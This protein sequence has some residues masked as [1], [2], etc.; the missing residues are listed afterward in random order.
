MRLNL[1]LVECGYAIG[2]QWRRSVKK[3]KNKMSSRI[4]NSKPA[5]LQLDVVVGILGVA[6]QA[7]L[8][9]KVWARGAPCRA[10]GGNAIPAPHRLAHALLQLVTVSVPGAEPRSVGDAQELAVGAVDV[11]VLHGAVVG[12]QNRR[13]RLRRQVDAFVEAAPPHA[14]PAAD[15][16]VGARHG[17]AE[18]PLGLGVLLA[19]ARLRGVAVQGQPA[20]RAALAVQLLLRQALGHPLAARGGRHRARHLQAPQPRAPEAAPQLALLALW[21]R[22]AL[23]RRD[24]QA[25]A[26]RDVVVLHAVQFL[27][28][29]HGDAVLARQA[30]QR[31][32]SLHLHRALRLRLYVLLRLGSNLGRRRGGRSLR[33]LA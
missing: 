32:P 4:S 21:T 19:E 8:K 1:Q 10:D 2:I 13:A 17:A 28:A 31:V 7:D 22:G 30:G 11:R 15:V 26:R 5:P 6:L 27:D 16:A 24:A 3:Q 12:G 14:V 33:A 25:G 23:P 9:V 20:P 29:A 18:L